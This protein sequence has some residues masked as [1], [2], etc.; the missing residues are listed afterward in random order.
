MTSRRL[1]AIMFS[2]IVGY[3]S[4]LQRNEEA[5]LARLARYRQVLE[6]NTQIYGGE[7]LQHLGDGSLCIF[8]SSVDALKCAR[9][10]QLTLRQEPTVPLRISLHMGD[11]ARMGEDYFGDGINVASRVE[12]IGEAG[13]VLLT[14]RVLADVFNHPEFSTVYIGSFEF[15]N[16]N[17]PVKVYALANQGLVVPTKKKAYQKATMMKTPAS[18][19]R[20]PAII[21]LLFLLSMWIF[22]RYFN[23][24]SDSQISPSYRL[25]VLPFENSSGS[26]DLDFACYGI[27]E[28]LIN[29]LSSL[30]GISVISKSSSFEVAGVTDDFKSIR[31]KLGVNSILKGAF[32]KEAEKVSVQTEF[33]D[34]ATGSSLWNG[35]FSALPTSLLDLENDIFKALISEL[36]LGKPSGTQ[37][38]NDPD[39]QAY[40]LYLQGKFLCQGSAEQIE[41]GIDLLHQAIQIDRQFAQAYASIADA[42]YVQA[43]FSS[44]RREKIAGEGITAANSALALN[45]ELPQAHAAVGAILFNFQ[46]DHAAAEGELKKALALDPNDPIACVR[47]SNLLMAQ[48]RFDEA[49]LYAN[50]ALETDPIS[51]NSI[52]SVGIVN[53]FLENYE[54][55]SEMFEDA[56]ALHPNWTWG[57]VK[58]ALCHALNQNRNRAL[59][60]CKIAESQLGGW[61]SARHQSWLARV[62]Y[63]L[64]E[65]DQF[66]RIF[67]RLLEGIEKD[68]IEDPFA[69][70]EL[71]GVQE[72]Q[73]KM[74]DWLEICMQEKSPS[75]AFITIYNC[76]DFIP[77]EFK[78]NPRYKQL[79]A[80]VGSQN[81]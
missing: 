26:D 17:D 29:R 76:L 58:G 22:S 20:W 45:P 80:Q 37:I 62:Y 46:W 54:K 1:A 60:L 6:D 31:E 77:M 70:A 79:L 13:S 51:T 55:A 53:Y 8:N 81:R 49:L 47:Y 12:P 40:Q 27:P 48:C 7:I 52:H 14:E 78:V 74:L 5:G 61:G 36:G 32:V 11:I 64:G 24:Q 16:V 34:A 42:R 39:P 18:M 63:E 30:K 15:K 75:M 9:D 33:L 68:Q 65:M 38:N 50:K 57:I 69:I 73:E 56:I 10:L 35:Q 4:M 28:N 66:N 43:F 67:N 2:D 23:F 19:Y 25:A 72:D 41:R 71:Y 44:V 59:E 3:T 21:I